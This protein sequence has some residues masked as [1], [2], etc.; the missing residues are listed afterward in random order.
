MTKEL[1]Q[2]M[3]G[4]SAEDLRSWG[5]SAAKEFAKDY[6]SAFSRRLMNL[7][8]L[9]ASVSTGT[10]GELKSAYDAAGAKRAGISHARARWRCT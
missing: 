10:W 2:A 3:S 6:A 4:T 9:A 7:T 5:T 1:R 8:K